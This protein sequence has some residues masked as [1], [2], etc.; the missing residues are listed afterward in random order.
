MFIPVGDSYSQYIWVIDKREDGTLHKE[1]SMGVRYVPRFS[2]GRV[3]R[4]GHTG[5]KIA[6]HTSLFWTEKSSIGKSIL[7]SDWGSSDSMEAYSSSMPTSL[8][9][10][11][12][13]RI[14]TYL[15]GLEETTN[16]Y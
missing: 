9:L 14:Q 7:N 3:R 10:C 12:Y 6:R 15:G 16:T 13:R 1:K 4:Y 11:V 8:F 2:R 5:N